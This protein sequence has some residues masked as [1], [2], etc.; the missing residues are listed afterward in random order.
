MGEYYDLGSH[1]WGVSTGSAEAQVWFDR[2][3]VWTYAF[4]HEEAVRCFQRALE[5]DRECA[6]AQ[7]GV[8][9]AAGPNYN[10]PW[11]AFDE[12]DLARSLAIARRAMRE[13]LAARAAAQPHEQ[14]LIDALAARY[15]ADELSEDHPIWNVDYAEAM[16]KVYAEH[17]DDPNVASL[18]AEALM[19]L[20]P[21]ELWD[22]DAGSPAEG[23]YTLE[24]KDVL[25]TALARPGG[26]EHPG[27]LHMYIHLMEMSPEPERALRAADALRGLV[28][29]AGHLEHMPTHI[30]VLCG[31][32][33][34]VVSSNAAAIAADEKYLAREGAQNF[35]SLYRCHDYH[36]K[37][38]G[39][40]FLGQYGPAIE[41]ADELV[42][43]LPEELLRLESPPMADWLEGFVPMRLHVLIRF[44]K[45]DEII[46]TELPEDA[47]LFCTTTAMIRYARGV[48]LAA[49]GRVEESA[50]EQE[51]FEQARARVPDT[52]YVFNNTCVDI[53]AIAAEMLA[54]ELE[55]RR[56]SFEQAF[57]HLRASIALDDGLPY[58]EP[59]GWMQP[60]R[61]AY[62]ALLLE[63]GRVEEA[64]AVYRADL[65]L[66]GSLARAYQHPDN[67]W[68]LHGFH[69]CLTSL[70]RD[71]EADIVK[72]RLGLALART[73]VPV[74]ASCYCR[75]THG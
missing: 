13:A 63:Q 15:P 72:Q 1:S 27:L 2:G 31:H 53:L 7:W 66:D 52:R 64:E 18:F 41:A 35:Y 11:E 19:N 43:G 4:N 32:Y 69:E 58:D 10:K 70:G 26:Y 45:W 67:V 60:T 3:L 68:S 50:A 51:L 30:D 71:A 34:K 49:S 29:D 21:W 8:S 20:T 23:A 24:A 48:A 61:H 39:A 59:W 38:Y 73:D 65:G 54:G 40:M 9:Y 6:M 17:G 37:L 22:L 12:A 46:A 75:L 33:D 36:F 28:P 16:R 47:E 5:H 55:Y 56:G 25:E 74:R 44:G 62:G 57:A 14:A 42:A